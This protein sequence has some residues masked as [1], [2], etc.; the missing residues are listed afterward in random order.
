MFQGIDIVYTPIT[1]SSNSCTSCTSCNIST[2]LTT[3]V[4][5]III[6]DMSY[7]IYDKYYHFIILLYLYTCKYAVSTAT[8]FVLTLISSFCDQYII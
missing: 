2:I 1:N 6:Y 3:I 7:I 4:T 5:T 8:K